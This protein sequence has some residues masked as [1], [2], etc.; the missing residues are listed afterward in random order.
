MVWSP[1]SKEANGTKTDRRGF[2]ESCS[3]LLESDEAAVFVE[4]LTSRWLV[5]AQRAVRRNTPVIT[6]A[7]LST[8]H[9]RC[10]EKSPVDVWWKCKWEPWCAVYSVAVREGN[11]SALKGPLSLW[12]GPLPQRWKGAV[13]ATPSQH[14]VNEVLL[15][16]TANWLLCLR[17]T[18]T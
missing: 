14:S 11:R 16:K 4:L 3:L 9:H 10:P 17:A 5:D 1:S 6:T 7:G 13:C 18:V 12:E 15:Q 2:C 8:L